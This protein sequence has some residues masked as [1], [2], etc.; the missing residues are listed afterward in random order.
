MK[1]V[2]PEITYK[3]SQRTL[4]TKLG[5]K[6]TAKKKFIGCTIWSQSLGNK[7]KFNVVNSIDKSG[8][9]L[10]YFFLD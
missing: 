5:I 4:A 9:H 6:R 10:V 2:F 7:L 8:N 1:K 3:Q